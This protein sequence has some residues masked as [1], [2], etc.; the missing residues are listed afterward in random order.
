MG[1]LPLIR[2]LPVRLTQTTNRGLKLFK[3]RRCTIAGWTLHP[4]EAAASLLSRICDL[5][6]FTCKHLHARAAYVG[7]LEASAQHGAERR[8]SFH[9]KCVYLKFE[10]ATWTIDDLEPGVYPLV[11][12]NKVWVVHKGSN[13][14]IKRRGF[15]IVPDFSATAHMTQGGCLQIK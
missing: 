9:P 14:K 15:S 6:A 8:L 12:G 2:G 1:L 11:P 10:N 5:F 3:H 7:H 4:E 13:I